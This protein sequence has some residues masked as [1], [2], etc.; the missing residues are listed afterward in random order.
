MPK[1]SET[2]LGKEENARIWDNTETEYTE[3][4][5]VPPP[6]FPKIPNKIP[7]KVGLDSYY[8]NG[9]EQ[10]RII[11]GLAMFYLY[12]TF[13]G[14]GKSDHNRLSFDTLRRSNMFRIQSEVDDRAEFEV[15]KEYMEIQCQ[16]DRI[17]NGC[18]PEEEEEEEEE[19]EWI[20]KEEEKEEELKDDPPDDLKKDPDWK[21]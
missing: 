20:E 6:R 5:P 16:N 18:F 15:I 14:K 8:F 11:R 1:R 3:V 7:E 12:K 9:V 4:E 21:P 2:S 19:E 10:K 13:K 17:K